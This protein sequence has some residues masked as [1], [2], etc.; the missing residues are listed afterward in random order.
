MINAFD[1]DMMHG[2]INNQRP[3]VQLD[4]DFGVPDGLTVDRE[5]YVWCAIYGGW[6]VMRYDPSGT[7]AEEIKMPVSRPSSCAFGGKDFR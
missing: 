7:A 5:G 3:F 4:A 1:F 6:K 2:T